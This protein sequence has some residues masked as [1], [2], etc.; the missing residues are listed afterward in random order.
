MYSKM[1]EKAICTMHKQDTL[2]TNKGPFRGKLH[3][4]L[5][6]TCGVKNLLN[7]HK[8]TACYRAGDLSR[9]YPILQ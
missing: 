3:F 5:L 7:G 9:V 1:S 8:T 6:N 4:H 2:L